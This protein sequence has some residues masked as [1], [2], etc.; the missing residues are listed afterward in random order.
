MMASSH[1]EQRA[2]VRH[3]V[4]EVRGAN[5][6]ERDFT[7]LDGLIRRQR[8]SEP[9]LSHDARDNVAEPWFDDGRHAIVDG[10]DLVGVHIDADHV[11][12]VT[13]QARC[14]HASHI[15]QAEDA[16]IHIDL[17]RPQGSGLASERAGVGPLDWPSL[18]S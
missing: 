1:V 4:S 9:A 11:M 17:S 8:G 16:D 13:R 10:A 12:S 6:D 7:S 5:A 18:D 2:Q 3:A 15:S 14:R